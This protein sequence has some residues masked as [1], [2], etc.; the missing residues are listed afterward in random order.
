MSYRIVLTFHEPLQNFI[1][2]H[3]L[4]Q[5][6]PVPESLPM[7]TCIYVSLCAKCNYTYIYILCWG[8]PVPDL[9]LTDLIWV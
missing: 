9:S 6:H 7:Y 4:Q 5:N 2:L 8:R 1:F 3:C